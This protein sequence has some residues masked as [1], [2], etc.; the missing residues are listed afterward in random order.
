[1]AKAE[2]QRAFADCYKGIARYVPDRK[3][4]YCYNDGVWSADTGSLRTM[5]RVQLE[6]ARR[7]NSEKRTN[8]CSPFSAKLVCG[9]CGEF[10][11]PKVWHSNSKYRRTIWQCNGKFK[12][13]CKCRTPHLYEDD[14]KERF[15]SAL[16]ELLADR[17]TLL[18]N[19]RLILNE[20]TDCS[21]IDTELNDISVELDLLTGLIRNYIAEN[22][23]TAIEQS[24][25]T[26]H[27]NKLTDKHEELQ[28]RYAEL[29]RQREERLCKADALGEFLFR[30]SELDLLELSFDDSLWNWS[31]ERV[32]VFADGEM[33]F[34]FKNGMEI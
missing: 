22:A 19:G 20:L 9:D 16:S 1:M 17:E 12:G 27:Y 29:R 8:C 13:E 31:V 23:V 28:N 6:I 14:I 34:R 15:I 26:E 24:D 2:T 7:R 32:T 10:Y 4:W 30:L 5:E 21:E 33:R 3:S 18:D 25:Y 11:G